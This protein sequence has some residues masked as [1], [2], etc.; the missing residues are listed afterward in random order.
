MIIGISAKKQCGKDTVGDIIQYLTW[1]KNNSGLN[2]YEE[3]CKS[4]V[5]TNN[6]EIK[7]F[8]D[9]LKDVVCLVIG[10]TREDLENEVFK[11][12][13]VGEEW[14][15]WKL[16]TTDGNTHYFINEEQA[17][18]AFGGYQINEEQ[19]ANAFGSY[20]HKPEPFIPTPRFF[21]QYIGSELF[22]FQLHEN[23][24]VNATMT[25]YKPIDD[26]PMYFGDRIVDEGLI[27]PNWVI[28]DV[29]FPNEA[30]SIKERGGI[31]IRV[32]RYT[33]LKDNHISETAL[34]NYN[35]FDYVID[36]NGTIDDL[37]EKVRGILI[38]NNII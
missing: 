8:A 31:I 3:W 11:S 29:R 27:Y 7:K 25:D 38:E 6:W 10:C 28:T 32:N 33:G 22:R 37:I 15:I 21:L 36:N 16:T 2:T 14:K 26:A 24:W 5:G 30:K 23:T 17:A 9:K 35:D 20:Y 4:N 1:K 18:N 12:T 13:E 34:D 19:A